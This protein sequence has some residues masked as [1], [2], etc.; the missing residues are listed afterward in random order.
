LR[1]TDADGQPPHA[2]ALRSAT[3]T[4]LQEIPLHLELSN[5][6][7][8]LGNK[9]IIAFLLLVPFTLEDTGGTFRL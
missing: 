7:V 1:A 2:A 5:L 3:E 8:Q 6:L 4:A 9:G